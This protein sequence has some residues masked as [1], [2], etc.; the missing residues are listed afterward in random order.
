MSKPQLY[1]KEDFPTAETVDS[2]GTGSD[3]DKPTAKR[4]AAKRKKR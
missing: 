4:K 3:A 2:F 1:Y